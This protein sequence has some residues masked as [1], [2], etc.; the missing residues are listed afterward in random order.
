MKQG[1][2]HH[3]FVMSLL[4]TQIIRMTGICESCKMYHVFCNGTTVH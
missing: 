2:M 1:R 3:P 4:I